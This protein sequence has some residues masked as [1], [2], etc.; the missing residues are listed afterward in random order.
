MDPYIG[1][2]RIF[3]CNYAPKGWAFCNGQPQYIA[4]NSALFAILGTTYGGDGRTTFNL[5]DLRD[6]VPLFWGNGAG[7]SAYTIGETG[8]TDTVTLLSNQLAAHNHVPMGSTGNE[9]T[10]PIG[11]AWGTGTGRTP[12]PMYVSGAPNTSM[13]SIIFNPTGGGYPHN[14][15][16][17]FLTLNFCIA[18]QGIFPP[19]P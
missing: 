18:I 2:I 8:G 19:R 14:N 12:P 11:N 16:Q 4:Q 1:E 6:R 9:Q 13:S 3:S 17:P 7:L 15:L 10:S 5:P